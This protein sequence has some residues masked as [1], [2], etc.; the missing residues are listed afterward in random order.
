MVQ[1]YV[2]L[3]QWLYSGFAISYSDYC[4]PLTKGN[5]KSVGSRALFAGLQAS[6]SV[7]LRFSLFFFLD[8]SLR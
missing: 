8:V 1:N 5:K 4:F 6:S 7:W 3:Y 2:R